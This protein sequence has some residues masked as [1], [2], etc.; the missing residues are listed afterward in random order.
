MTIIFLSV[1]VSV[2]I[3]RW[4]AHGLV[5]LWGLDASRLSDHILRADCLSPTFSPECGRDIYCDHPYKDTAPYSDVEMELLGLMM[6][7]VKIFFVQGVL[8]V[9]VTVTAIELVC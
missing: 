5:L 9:C 4:S 3:A 7:V 2:L 6:S 1:T 8:Q